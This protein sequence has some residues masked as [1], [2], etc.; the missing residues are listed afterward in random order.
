MSRFIVCAVLMLAAAAAAPISAEDDAIGWF[1]AIFERVKR[2]EDAR[3]TVPKR[4]KPAPSS[5]AAPEDS[6]SVPPFPEA[7]AR[8]PPEDSES[9]PLFPEAAAHVPP[10]DSESVPLFPEAVARVPLEDS[11]PVE[12]LPAAA[13]GALAG[14]V[15]AE[16]PAAPAP[17]GVSGIRDAARLSD[18]LGTVEAL[19]AEIEIIRQASG[20]TG[21]P[22]EAEWIEGRVPIHMYAKSLEVLA[23]VVEVQRRL[24]VPEGRVGPIPL[25][26]IGADDVASSIEY[27]LAEVRRIRSQLGIGRPIAPEPPD[28]GNASPMIY[29]RLTDA[30]F[31]LDGLRGGPLT[32]DDVYRNALSVLDEM[33]L[34]AEKLDVSLDLEPAPITGRRHSLD[35]AMEVARAVY[36]VTELQTLLHMDASGVPRPDLARVTS[37]SNYDSTNMLLAEM[38]RIKLHLGID[39]PREDRPEQPPGK[40][41]RDAVALIALIVQNLDRMVLATPG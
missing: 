37:S 25:R 13:A 22:V 16:A 5:P 1:D 23:K 36:K 41:A 19:I 20:V 11:G 6:E 32:P 2:S 38:A 15:P 35:V 33:A 24:D 12:P 7:A 31:M 10:E 9:V 28:A 39:A 17:D 27:I 4:R 40:K 30:S 3:V 14:H 8:V 26:N 34:I 21:Y 18:A 29:K